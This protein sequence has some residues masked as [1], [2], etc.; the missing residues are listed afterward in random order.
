MN[1]TQERVSITPLE[2]AECLAVIGENHFGRIAYSFHD[3]VNIEPISYAFDNDWIFGRTS[4]GSKWLTLQHH[5]WVAFEVEQIVSQFDWRTVVVQG[6]VK[7]LDESDTSS[8][9]RKLRERALNAIRL[10]APF[11]LTNDDPAPHRDKV[12]GIYLNEVSGRK[13]QSLMHNK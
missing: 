6:T 4:T 3:R 8:P 13:S 12:F 2:R 9:D 1:K 10:H 5:P 11:A 7:F